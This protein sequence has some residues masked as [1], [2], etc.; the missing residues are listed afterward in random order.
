MSV[1]IEITPFLQHLTDGVTVVSVNGNTI[2]DCLADLVRQFPRLKAALLD[3]DG[4]LR[5]YIE[6]LVNGKN[7]YPE[8][9]AQLVKDRDKIYILNVIAGG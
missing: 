8:E 6:I 5:K 3:R 9:L 1:Q 4:E 2:G 7:A